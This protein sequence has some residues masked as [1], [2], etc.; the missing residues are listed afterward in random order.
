MDFLS[1]IITAGVAVITFIFT[2]LIRKKSSRFARRFIAF[3]YRIMYLQF[4]REWKKTF[5]IGAEMTGLL[6]LWIAKL[7][8]YLIEHFHFSKETKD[9]LLKLPTGFWTMVAA[10]VAAMAA[11]V[12]L[13]VTQV[14][15][16]LSQNTQLKHQKE[17]M[18]EQF[19]HQ[20]ELAYREYFLDKRTS[21]ILDFQKTLEETKAHITY[22]LSEPAD[23]DRR[24]AF[25]L[26]YKN[27]E[28]PQWRGNME[29]DGIRWI[30]INELQKVALEQIKPVQEKINELNASL[31]ILTVYLSEDEIESI[32][33]LIER[34]DYLQH[35]IIGNLKGIKKS[36]DKN[37]FMYVH[38]GEPGEP[39][40]NMV[41]EIDTFHK[42]VR[43]LLKKYLYIHKLDA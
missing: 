1:T 35:F 39:I 27:D 12:T 6:G 25:M 42:D 10:V 3:L 11:M 32:K 21:A 31:N 8:W 37:I 41:K 26:E 19:S 36:T 29:T 30:Q 7:I 14:M 20:R 2:Q 22:F 5:G 34:I 38:A 23:L 40:T 13:I 43:A 24:T 33:K 9:F 17:M 4:I 18:S 15:N 28:E 16:K